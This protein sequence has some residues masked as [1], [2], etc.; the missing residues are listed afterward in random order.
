MMTRSQIPYSPKP[1]P[2]SVSQIKITLSNW[3]KAWMQL[4]LVEKK[5]YLTT[6]IGY[7][8]KFQ[9]CCYFLQSVKLSGKAAR[10]SVRC[11][12][13][14]RRSGTAKIVQKFPDSSEGTKY[15]H[16]RIPQ[17]NQSASCCCYSHVG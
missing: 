17:Q 14:C 9:T 5:L 7:F 15:T 16:S 11:F 1:Y 10:I 13:Q 12:R 4:Q 3:S 8:I 6:F 2:Y